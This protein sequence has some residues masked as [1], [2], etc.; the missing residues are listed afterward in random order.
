M[1]TNTLN[2]VSAVFFGHAA[3]SNPFAGRFLLNNYKQCLAIIQENMPEVEK[4][5][6]ASDLQDADFEQ[7]LVE[8]RM[9]LQNLK[10][11]PEEKVLECAYI[12][13]LETKHQ[14]E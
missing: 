4:M 13:A 5:K 6:T 9:F 11:E 7:W 8:E 14:A 1:M 3:F 12:H 2:S 10:D